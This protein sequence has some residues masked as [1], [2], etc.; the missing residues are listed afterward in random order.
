ME[1][2]F[3]N[4]DKEDDDEGVHCAASLEFRVFKNAW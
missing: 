1:K 2:V 4:A 3:K